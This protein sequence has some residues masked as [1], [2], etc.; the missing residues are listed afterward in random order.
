VEPLNYKCAQYMDDHA[1][2]GPKALWC[3]GTE[4]DTSYWN[5]YKKEGN[6]F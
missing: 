4:G 5:D 3:I 2:Y 6:K 1:L